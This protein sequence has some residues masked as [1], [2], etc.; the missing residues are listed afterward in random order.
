[1]IITPLSKENHKNWSY[2]GLNNYIH[3]QKD[4][5]APILIAEINKV[6]NTNPI[7][8]IRDGDKL[9]LYSL[10]SLFPEQNHMIDNHGKWISNYIP[11]RY[12]SLPFVL[13]KN[14]KTNNDDNE[15]LLCFV[16][17]LKCV[18]KKFETKSTKI[19]NKSGELSDEMKQVFD[20]LQSIEQNELLTQKALDVINNTD[21]LEDWPVS[22]KFADG[23]KKMNGLL[24]VNIDKLRNL[25]LDNI[26]SLTSTGGIDICFANYFS[27]NNTELLKNFA[28]KKFTGSTKNNEPEEPKSLR[29][30]TLEK[31]NKEKKEEMDSLVKDLL[32]D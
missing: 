19:F 8:F 12:R 16:D 9:G 14:S 11:A 28:I 25:P 6:V 7:V 13:A 15:K 32:L 20:F 4:A 29:D 21:I 2:V 27:Q 24:R 22:V 18:S 1:M 17:N 3:T 26:Q 10:Q 5:I 30:L 23:E 31:Q